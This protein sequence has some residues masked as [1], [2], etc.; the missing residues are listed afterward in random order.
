[1]A[2]FRRMQDQRSGQL[3]EWR[4]REILF[5]GRMLFAASHLVNQLGVTL[6]QTYLLNREVLI[7]YFNPTWI[8]S[9]EIL[10]IIITFYNAYI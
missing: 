3:G 1:M 5:G 6:V 2:F 10:F 7:Q 9:Q 8:S 4:R